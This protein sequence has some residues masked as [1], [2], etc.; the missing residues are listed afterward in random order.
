[1]SAPFQICFGIHQRVKVFLEP[2]DPKG[3]VFLVIGFFTFW[4][5]LKI[6]HHGFFV[7]KVFFHMAVQLRNHGLQ[8]VVIQ[9]FFT[10]EFPFEPFQKIKQLLVFAVDDRVSKFVGV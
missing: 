3:V 2:H 9:A 4:H 10:E 8:F 6:F 5:L 7:P 1:M